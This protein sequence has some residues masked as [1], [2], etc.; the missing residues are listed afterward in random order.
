MAE[1]MLLNRWS[2]VHPGAFTSF[3]QSCTPLP[4]NEIQKISAL[5]GL[6]SWKNPIPRS[7]KRK[8]GTLRSWCGSPR[9][10]T[11]WRNPKLVWSNRNEMDTTGTKS[12]S[13][14]DQLHTTRVVWMRG[15]VTRNFTHRLGTLSLHFADLC[16]SLQIDADLCRSMQ[17]HGPFWP[18][19]TS[20][21]QVFRC[22]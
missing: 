7:C 5:L 9:P 2:S 13:N 22:G 19:L 3:A 21:D 17:L 6:W 8:F 14:R 18:F 15:L 20:C 16:R 11:I 12:Y 1:D 10:S 4:A